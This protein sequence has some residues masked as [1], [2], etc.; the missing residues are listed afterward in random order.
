MSSKDIPLSKSREALKEI[1]AALQEL[2][3]RRRY[4]AIDFFVPYPKQAAFFD[5]GGSYSERMLSAGN[6]QG[7]SQAGAAE[8][9]YHLT[10]QY[11][12]DW[13]GRKWE[14][15]IKAWICGESALVVRDVQQQKLCG[16]PG[17]EE[18]FG[19]GMIP[20]AC[21]EGKPS[22][23]RGITDAYDTIHVKHYTNGVYD[24]VS[25]ARFKSYEQGRQKFQGAPVDLI[26]GDEE[27]PMDVYT[28]MLARLTATNGSIYVTFTPMN[29]ITELWQ[30]FDLQSKDRIRV[31]MTIKDALHIDTPEKLAKVLARYPAHEHAA[32][33]NGQPMMGEGRVFTVLEEAI[34]EPTLTYIPPAWTK[35]FSIDFGIGHPFAC[36][37]QAWDRDN[38]VIHVLEAWRVR[39]Q[40][41]LQHAVRMKQIGIMVPVAWPQDGTAREK[42]GK[43]V[44]SLYEEAGLRMLPEHATF[45]DGGYGTEAGILEMD[46]RFKSGRLKVAAH[47]AEWFEE[48]RF[49]HR[50]N[51]LIEKINDDIMSAT[52]IGVMAKRKGQPVQL[53]GLRP[54][55]RRGEAVAAGLDF[56]PFS[57]Q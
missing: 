8:M 6:Q 33:I 43:T 3:D 36:T 7:K 38:D 1:A 32:R 10:G 16:E 4:R 23:A 31:A 51:G 57:G 12:P 37:L 53:G 47:L 2:D 45:E 22:M 13:L 18:A 19:T 54:N 14:R 11:P 35:L 46:E 50:K 30:R 56:D 41:P 49:Y 34:S 21:F 5:Y 44:S 52:R 28:E 15:P 26:W 40:T 39:D 48:Y 42:S 55:R 9:A 25:V 17:L 29:G 20:K 24:G 27:P